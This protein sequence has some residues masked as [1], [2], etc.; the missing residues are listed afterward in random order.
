MPGP[1]ECWVE[2]QRDPRLLVVPQQ[3]AEEQRGLQLPV[4]CC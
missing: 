1:P 3:Q 2:R 4:H